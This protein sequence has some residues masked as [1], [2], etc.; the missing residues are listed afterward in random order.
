MLSFLGGTMH[1]RLSPLALILFAFALFA[2]PLAAETPQPG[3]IADART[4]CRVWN[5]NPEPDPKTTISWSG[6]CANGLAQGRGVLQWFVDG[7]PDQRYEGAFRDGKENGRGV[8][9]Y[10]DGSRYVGE[11][12]DGKFNGRGTYTYAD[13]G[14]YEGEYRDGKADGQGVY[15]WANGARYEGEFSDG[16]RSGRGAFTS[17]EG[18]R[19]RG[20]YRDNR[21]NGTGTFKTADGEALSGTWVNGCL[22]ED[23]SWAA[24]GVTKEECGF[25]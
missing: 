10:T 22:R 21:P 20:Q 12:R 19:Y 24:V 9:T 1:S 11:Y 17:A 3:W 15:S 13:G 23:D 6:A 4:D 5:R 8:L 14:R 7:K 18:N 2:C 25:K 16:K